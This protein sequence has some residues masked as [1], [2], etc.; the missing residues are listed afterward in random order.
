MADVTKFRKCEV[1]NGTDWNE[2]PFE[3]IR[4]GDTF[5]MTEPDGS[6]VTNS[7]G[8]HELVAL[9]DPER[10]DGGNWRVS[11]DDN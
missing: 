6:K 10:L 3:N 7:A 8:D 2:V 9:C 11:V 1:F 4:K 5:R